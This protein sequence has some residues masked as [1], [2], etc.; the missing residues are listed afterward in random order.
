MPKFKCQ[1]KLK[2]QILKILILNFE[3]HLTFGPALAGLKFGI[4]Y[5]D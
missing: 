2:S 4:S 3:I 1:I 5:L